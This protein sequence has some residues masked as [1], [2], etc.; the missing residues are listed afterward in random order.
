MR[1]F[2]IRC[3]PARWRDRYGDEFLAVLEERALG[4]FDMADIL[5]GALDAQLR[6]RRASV[7]QG[8]SLSMSL[9]I[10]G[11]AAILGSA[12]LAIAGFLGSGLIAV[13]GTVAS[14]FLFTGLGALL[15]ALAG[16]S[17]FQARMYPRLAW[18]AFGVTAVGTVLVVVLFVGVA[19]VGD[20]FADSYWNVGMVGLLSALAG[21]ALFAVVTYRTAVLSRPAAVLLGLGSV[22][23]FLGIGSS[24]VQ[25]LMLLAISCF[26][27]GWFGLGFQAIRLD[28]PA[29]AASS[30]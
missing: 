26:L 30:V 8:R 6:G 20:R 14:V 5:I 17:A 23:P 19:I 24:N 12:L 28:R 15:V 10:G 9:R 16:L 11:I 27:L 4:P 25:G 21:S 7:A 1:S 13:N 29:G 18:A 3:Y 22:L 2:L